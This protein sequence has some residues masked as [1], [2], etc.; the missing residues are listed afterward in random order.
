MLHTISEGDGGTKT[1]IDAAVEKLEQLIR[2]TRKIEV[3]SAKFLLPE[4]SGKFVL[5]YPFAP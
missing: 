4:P 3:I 1:A 2:P 5:V